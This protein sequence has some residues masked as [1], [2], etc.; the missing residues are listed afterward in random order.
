MD[1]EFVSQLESTRSRVAECLA[2]SDAPTEEA[3][4]IDAVSGLGAGWT[5]SNV[6]P[7]RALR[8]FPHLRLKEGW[9]LLGFEFRS[10]ENGNGVVYAIPACS[11]VELDQAPPAQW[12]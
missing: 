11:K 1:S 10:G 12:R 8:Y 7:G 5:V 6:D 4:A 9:K 2:A 3:A